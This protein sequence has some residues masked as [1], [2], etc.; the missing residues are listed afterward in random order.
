MEISKGLFKSLIKISALLDKNAIRHCL[1][2]GLAVSIVSQPRA[3]EDIDFAVLLEEA[4]KEKL[5][6]ILKSEFTVLQFQKTIMHLHNAAIQRALIRD[7][8]DPEGVVIID[9]LFPIN[10]V[11]IRTVEN[12]VRINT[13]GVSIPVARAE[14]LILMKTLA[15]R[16]QDIFDIEAIKRECLLDED[17]IKKYISKNTA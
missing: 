13:E 14:D 17:Y 1:T 9:F 11:F 3:T 5:E 6:T 2:G 10:E 16:P 4:E 12:A 7:P 8:L 15:G